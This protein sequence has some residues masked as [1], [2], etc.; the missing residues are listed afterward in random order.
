MQ[1][2]EGSAS[3]GAVSSTRIM[4]IVVA[5]LFMVVGAIVIAD[6]IRVGNT[7]LDPVGPQAGYFPFYVGVIMSVAS[8][9]TL[10]QAVLARKG[11]T[12]PFVDRGAFRQV[13]LVLLPSVVFVL[14]VG[15]IGIYVASAIFIGAFMVY[16]G[17]YGA[18]R[19]AVVS[20]AV[21]VV[22]FFMFEVW[23]LVPLPKG[24]IEDWLGL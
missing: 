2:S 16:F 22:L 13:L 23:F 19:T 14:A 3:R 1:K 24:P 9:I 21:P 11:Y 15:F 7:W 5:V 20:I 17:R 10:L 6:S 4:E 12:K 8:A 18:I